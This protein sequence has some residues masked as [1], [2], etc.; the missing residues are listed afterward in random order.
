MRNISV[1]P[2]G[3]PVTCPIFLSRVLVCSCSVAVPRVNSKTHIQPDPQQQQAIE[4]V[5]GP[6]LVVA[7]AGT[8]KTTVLTRRIA[9]LVRQ[10]H[11]RPDEILVLT[12]T[13]NAAEEMLARL[14]AQLGKSEAQQFQV[15]TFHDYC[16]KLLIRAGRDFKVLDD[17][18]LWVFLRRG[19][20]E[21]RLNYF[22]RA[23]NVTKFLDDLLDFIRRCHDELIGPE[24][25]AD[26]VRRVGLGEFPA[27]RVSKS[28]DAQDLTAEEALGRC[29]E[30]AFV[31]ETVERMLREGNLGTFGHQILRAYQLLTEDSRVLEHE[32]SRLRFI[33]VDEFQDANFAQIRIL[34]KLS[35]EGASPCNVFAVGDPDQAIYRF[36]GASSEAF[37]LFQNAFPNSQLVVLSTNRRSTTPILNCAHAVIAQNPGFALEGDGR[38]C[39]RTPLISERDQ[40]G[41][42]K[43]EK[44][45]PVDAVIVSSSFMEATDLVSKLLEVR[46]RS[47]SKWKDIAVLY[48]SHTHREEVAAELARKGIPFSIEALDVMDAPEVRDLLAAL[49]AVV[50]PADSGSWLRAAALRRF[51][52]DPDE[53]R[54]AIKGLPRDSKQGLTTV[55]PQVK[56]GTELL[57]RVEQTRQEISGK[58]THAALLSVIRLFELPRRPAI[59]AV[60]EFASKWEESPLTATKEP[61]EFLEY[62]DLFREARGTIAL[63][64]REDEDSVKL[65]TVHGAKG[66]EFDH[67]LVL[68]VV[69]NCFPATYREPLIEFPPP[70]RNS[71][72]LNAL[73]DK[74]LYE[75]EERRLFYVAMTRAR[76]TLTVYGPF[77]R[78]TKDKTPPGYLRELLKNHQ[79]KPWL[80]ERTCR[81][82]QTEIFA[83]AE[84]MPLDSQLA[85]WI[86]LPLGSNLAA[87]LSASAIDR[88]KVCP[89]QF[90]LEREW[91]IPAEVSAAVQYGASMHRVLRAFYDSVRMH[92]TYSES[93]LLELFRS[94]LASEAIADRYQHDLYERQGIAQLKQFL[95]GANQTRPD[96]L[97]S[98]EPFNVRLGDT[99]LVGRID[100][101][102]RASDGAVIITDYKTGRPMAQADADDS[103]QLS[104]YALAAREKWGYTAERLVFHNLEGNS[105]ISTRRSNIQLEEAR[106]EVIDIAQKIAAGSFE[107]KPGFQCNSCAYRLLC[108]KTEKPVPELLAIRAAKTN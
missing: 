55:L 3:A 106:R 97:H 54:A 39:R 85:E 50:S 28:K 8:G 88:Y 38:Q 56:G 76:D 100:R 51:S 17:K 69:S 75:Q 12:Y 1:F 70:L 86:A 71:S 108:P 4:H 48:R 74:T 5:D 105:T 93:A 45:A 91:R 68:K 60:L 95:T 35:G 79:I 98:E 20:H 99:N 53:L 19:I 9:H 34:Q 73:D 80:N 83:A 37:V 59:Q 23:A 33:L 94:D 13:V 62:L 43:S 40:P 44:R 36:R 30:I 26:Y 82:F 57:T 27:P 46:R 2:S 32:R 90:K 25:Y 49:G 21:L 63:P 87:T 15:H 58:K 24:Q 107:A 7:G 18:Q 96:V 61:G 16:F 41:R 64:V 66:L 29:R 89:L 14:E 78:G 52:L 101:I 103:L 10:G 84:P 81:E 42:E 102:D 72:S 104:L 67:V 92:R 47:R 77:G 6:M 22:V 11:A 65:M 31:F